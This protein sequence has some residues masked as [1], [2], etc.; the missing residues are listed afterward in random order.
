MFFIQLY[1]A[2]GLLSAS[3]DCV[4]VASSS[5]AYDDVPS[6]STS[7]TSQF[8]GY[9]GFFARDDDK[10]Q[11][12]PRQ[13]TYGEAAASSTTVANYT[14]PTVPPAE[15]PTTMTEAYPTLN[16]DLGSVTTAVS[17][18]QR[19]TTYGPGSAISLDDVAKNL[20]TLNTVIVQL[21]KTLA[22]TKKCEKGSVGIVNDRDGYEPSM[23]PALKV[24]GGRISGKR[25]KSGRV[26][27]MELGT[28][29]TYKPT[30][31]AEL[32]KRQASRNKLVKDDYVSSSAVT[33]TT[34]AVRPLMPK[35][36]PHSK[37]DNVKAL[38]FDSVHKSNTIYNIANEVLFCDVGDGPLKKDSCDVSGQTKN[39]TDSMELAE[40]NRTSDANEPS[41]NDKKA[42]AKK[43]N[44]HSP[45]ANHSL[46]SV[47]RKPC[48]DVASSKKLR[49][50]TT[51][52][53]CD[54]ERHGKHS[55]GKTDKKAKR[56][57]SE[58][59]VNDDESQKAKQE[60]KREHA[61]KLPVTARHKPRLNL[62]KISNTDLFGE[63]SDEDS[64]PEPEPE[65]ETGLPPEDSSSM[66]DASEKVS[67]SNQD[68]Q[69]ADE[70]A[71]CSAGETSNVV[72][73][74]GKKRMS[75]VLDKDVAVLRK[76]R[77]DTKT[78]SV[79]AK[80][81][82]TVEKGEKR[83]AHKMSAAV[84]EE[85][86]VHSKALSKNS[87]MMTAV[88]AI[89]RIRTACRSSDSNEHKPGDKRSVSRLS[90]SHSAIIGGKSAVINSFTLRRSTTLHHQKTLRDEDFYK[91]LLNYTL[92]E[93]QLKENGFPL[94]DPD[95]QG[96]AVYY[97]PEVAKRFVEAESLRRT[98]C[99]CG[100]PFEV[101][102]DWRY[103]SR[104][105][106]CIFH[107]GRPWKKREGGVIETR[108]NCC[109]GDLNSSGCSMAKFHVTDSSPVFFLDGYVQPAESADARKLIYS[110]DCE[111][112][113]TTLGY[114]LARITVIDTNLRQVYDE[115][116]RP[117]GLLLDCNSRY[118]GLTENQVVEATKLL[119]DVQRDLLQIFSA[120]TILV[121]HS[122]ECDLRAL[123]IIH[124]LIVDTSVVFPHRLGPP[125]K[126]ALKTL[127]VEYL[128]K[129][130]QDDAAG[131]DSKEDA[132]ACMELMKWKVKE[133]N[134][135]LF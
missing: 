56:R 40:R 126:R 107:Y 61:A 37:C 62:T 121:G 15:P 59:E 52:V 71:G 4:G 96:R 90:I 106:E 132:A 79:D 111:M 134:K 72:C 130:I 108:Y 19:S 82:R 26:T 83:V 48:E 60:K 44:L 95:N 13:H 39:E 64:E 89:K 38:A 92:D 3:I 30:P 42:A 74:N 25:T 27:F 51:V 23:K 5:L 45:K 53:I 123:K 54:E 124:R 47:K 133:E 131:H 127:M 81:T 97:K 35:L 94:A 129:I 77:T 58:K 116:V 57:S 91:L 86:A 100:A 76:K 6:Y 78:A 9:H 63:E 66:D 113:Y 34:T 75:N 1:S 103:S 41:L 125:F 84:E 43:S 98:C 109:Q 31:I 55:V 49:R 114:E 93:K 28:G 88:S 122:L 85:K 46:S 16:I 21:Q 101:T 102:A 7:G 17:A 36:D 67:E 24:E 69:Q 112:V 14:N 32:E 117:E 20:A 104:D 80:S 29:A 65:P 119:S 87:Y 18:L 99:R 11:P 120:N 8:Q 135:K 22:N 115:I 68:N 105:T 33:S 12:Q 118:S 70:V 50:K 128:K 73:A 10:M 2:F 110:L